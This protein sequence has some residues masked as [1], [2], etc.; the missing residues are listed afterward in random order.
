M[1]V[2]NFVERFVK[3]INHY[4][5]WDSPKIPRGAELT[6]EEE[7]REREQMKPDPD[8]V[9]KWLPILEKAARGEF[10]TE[11]LTNICYSPPFMP[12]DPEYRKLW[13]TLLSIGIMD[14]QIVKQDGKIGFVFHKDQTVTVEK[15]KFYPF[16]YCGGEEQQ[17]AFGRS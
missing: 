13:S 15:G 2:T 4:G 10:S 14:V 3:A 7:A 9:K 5:P 12:I 11:P 16:E 6:P 8:A 1:G 17:K